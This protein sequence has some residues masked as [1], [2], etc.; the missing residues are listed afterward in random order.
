M[1]VW[2]G[3]S[4]K[5]VFMD[6]DDPLEWDLITSG[7]KS[8]VTSKHRLLPPECVDPCI[9]M[10]RH[11]EYAIPLLVLFIERGELMEK[12]NNKECSLEGFASQAV[13]K[14][15][16]C[17]KTGSGHYTPTEKAWFYYFRRWKGESENLDDQDVYES[18]MSIVHSLYP[19]DL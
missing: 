16:W 9:V 15:H 10:A 5:T 13:W 3:R 6:I 4:V 12:L 7:N 18:V 19:T 8:R 2:D 17:R 1:S 14:R 11:R